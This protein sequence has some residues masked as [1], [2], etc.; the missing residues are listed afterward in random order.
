MS[1]IYNCHKW[2]ALFRIQLS[3]WCLKSTML[4]V[5]GVIVSPRSLEIWGKFSET[6]VWR[7]PISM[8]PSKWFFSHW[9]ACHHSLVAQTVMQHRRPGFDSW[10]GK[11]LWRGK[12]Y[13]FQYSCLENSMNR[14][15][16]RATVHGLAKSW[17]R[18]SN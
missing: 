6:C 7:A 3:E 15:A 4:E 16:W 14:G 13:P 9:I 17:T 10:I 2:T 1:S 12:G 18:L 8:F 11:I 5:F